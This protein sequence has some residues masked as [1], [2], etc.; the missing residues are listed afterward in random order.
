MK[1]VLVGKNGQLG[2]DCLQ[3][4]SKKFDLVALGS[5]ELDITDGNLIEEMVRCLHPEVVLNCAA[6][7]KVDACEQEQELA[8][9]INVTGVRH[10]ATSLARH[11]GKLLHISTDYVFDGQ[12]PIPE[13]YFE[14][15]AVAA[16][17]YYGQTKV[18]AELVIMQELQEYVIVRTAWLY[19]RHGNNFLKTML[20]LASSEP[21]PHIK[22]VNDQF[23]SP[24]WSYRLAE[25][26]ATIV[27]MGGQGIYHATSE[28]YTTW[29]DLAC[30]FLTGMGIA[31]QIEPC[32]TA[33]Y[34]TPAHRP[35][36]SILENR[37]LKA[38]G[39]NL[40]R[41]WQ[42]ELEEFI[43]TNRD[44]LIQEA[45]NTINGKKKLSGQAGE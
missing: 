25:Q 15:D 16:L 39:I 45:K 9:R 28:G 14:E 36:N 3:V 40:M 4:F 1:I 8:Y 21:A 44:I 12:K 34:P 2:K 41:P 11:G 10:L 19:G 32:T 31:P 27:G 30:A 5:K 26:L 20:R 17:S 43:L 35:K 24:T 42:N 33:D 22:V 6:Y 13:P 38:Q 7:T 18:E 37:H 23:G 29:F